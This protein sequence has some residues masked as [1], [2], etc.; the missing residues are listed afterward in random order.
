MVTELFIRFK[1]GRA[2]HGFF[3]YRIIGQTFYYNGYVRAKNSDNEEIGFSDLSDIK[4]IASRDPGDTMW[5]RVYS[6]DE[7]IDVTL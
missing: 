3:E 6:P 1:N 7:S 2:I 4:L 5:T